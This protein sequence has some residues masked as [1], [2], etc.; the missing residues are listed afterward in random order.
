MSER[1]ASPVREK[2]IT[3]QKLHESIRLLF[4]DFE[5]WANHIL[6]FKILQQPDFIVLNTVTTEPEHAHRTYEYCLQKLTN[7]AWRSKLKV[8]RDKSPA[9]V[10]IFLCNTVSSKM[11][12]CFQL[13]Y[14]Y[15]ATKI[16][17]CTIDAT[18]FKAKLRPAWSDNLTNTGIAKLLK[19][20]TFIVKLRPEDRARRQL[21]KLNS[22]VLYWAD[23]ESVPTP[24]DSA[25]LLMQQDLKKTIHALPFREGTAHDIY[26][27]VK[28]AMYTFYNREIYL[29]EHP[30][31]AQ[32][33]ILFRELAGTVD[34]AE[35]FHMLRSAYQK[36]LLK[37]EDFPLIQQHFNA[38][39]NNMKHTGRFVLSIR[40]TEDLAG[41]VTDSS[42]P[43]PVEVPQSWNENAGYW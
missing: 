35:F 9:N 32:A 42:K 10:F 2:P 1:D 3:R 37:V 12:A 29:S 11:G 14:L 18:R 8:P 36:K 7:N 30:F 5:Q 13:Y 22:L 26:T 38:H 21:L 17:G 43:I 41:I 15:Y 28:T 23:H 6:L 40:F 33:A 24:Y 4:S 34:F 19:H 39:V 27:L 16:R 20:P 25:K 31:T